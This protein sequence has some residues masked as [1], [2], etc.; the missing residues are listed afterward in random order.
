MSNTVLSKA[1][2]REV[3]NE[4]NYY[5]SK[6]SD[7]GLGKLAGYGTCLSM[8]ERMACS[9]DLDIKENQDASDSTNKWAEGK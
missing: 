1:E 3:L 6:L 8:D 5:A 7:I 4:I 9:M 2:R